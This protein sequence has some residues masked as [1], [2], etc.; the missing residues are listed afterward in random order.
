MNMVDFQEKMD[1]THRM[2][3]CRMLNLKNLPVGL[4]EHYAQVKRLVDRIDGH[5][6]PGDLAMIAISADIAIEG[7]DARL[8]AVADEFAVK[9]SVERPEKE[10]QTITAQDVGEDKE[11]ERILESPV[12][13]ATGQAVEKPAPDE[14]KAMLWS[15]GM[16]VHVLQDDEFKRGRIVGVNSP[17]AG[18]KQK[19]W[20]TVECE[21]GETVTA[22][23]DEVEAI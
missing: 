4:L 18:S 17:P 14:G 10:L 9:P 11:L 7:E 12:S 20:L 22:D 15:P 19:V 23:E 1:P 2:Y 3:L 16:P 8:Q 21:D 6:T 13:G 5:L